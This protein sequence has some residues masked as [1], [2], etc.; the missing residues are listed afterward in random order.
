MFE[1]GGHRRFFKLSIIHRFIFSWRDVSNR[2]EKPAIIE[3]V[4]PF[5]GCV[6]HILD[7]L[8]RTALTNDFR[9]VKTIDRF[10][11]GIVIRVSNTADR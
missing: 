3:P 11:Q 1:S 6:L 9:F 7:V 4:D 2:F 10:S 8:P 5:Q